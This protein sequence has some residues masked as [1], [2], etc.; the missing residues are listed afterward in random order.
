[1]VKE[2]LLKESLLKS[3]VADEA[4]LNENNHGLDENNICLDSSASRSKTSMNVPRTVS[5]LVKYLIFSSL[6]NVAL[7]GLILFVCILRQL[8]IAYAL[9]PTTSSFIK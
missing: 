6:K 3:V 7:L 1:M 5:S 4:H 2:S 8:L 9:G